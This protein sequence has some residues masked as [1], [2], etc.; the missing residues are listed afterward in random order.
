MNKE[1]KEIQSNLISIEVN[2]GKEEVI[3]EKK[4]EVIELEKEWWIK[5]KSITKMFFKYEYKI[6]NFFIGKKSMFLKTDICT[7]FIMRLLAQLA[8]AAILSPE[9]SISGNDNNSS[10]NYVYVNRDFACSVITLLIVEI[11]FFLFELCL[12]KYKVKKE[13]SREI[14]M[15]Y[16]YRGLVIHFI[17]YFIFLMILSFGFINTLWI[18]LTINVESR[19]KSF[20]TIFMVSQILSL[21]VYE[22]CLIFLK[23]S[24]FYFIVLNDN[25]PCWKKCLISIMAFLPWC[26]SLFG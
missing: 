2:N 5:F 17:I 24:I 16:R 8:V 10:E 23:S 6:G 3:P 12:S 14:K 11:P 4:E 15:K 20:L 9:N 22:T 1:K 13:W 25:I 21:F 19:D 26:V 18:S 7:L